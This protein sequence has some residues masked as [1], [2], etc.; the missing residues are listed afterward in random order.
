MPEASLGSEKKA[1]RCAGPF[2]ELAFR[3]PVTGQ[4]LCRREASAAAVPYC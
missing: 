1:R 2:A 4:D 3:A